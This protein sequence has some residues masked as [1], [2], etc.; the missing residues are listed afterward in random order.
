MRRS[1]VLVFDVFR[2]IYG[3]NHIFF[4]GPRAEIYL[5]AAFAAKRAKLALFGPDDL[6]TA[7]WTIDLSCHMSENSLEITK[8][9]LE[10]HI[11]FV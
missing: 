2:R 11:V 10:R 3:W 6:F 1:A 5:L 9:E 8:R 4:L 7:G